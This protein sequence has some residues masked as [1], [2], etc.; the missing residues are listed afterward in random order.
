MSSFRPIFAVL[1]AIACMSNIL[2]VVAQNCGCGDGVCC[3]Q[4]GYCGNTDPYCG[5]GCREGPCSGGS[6]GGGGGGSGGGGSISDMVT[7]AFFNGI[8]DQ[9]SSSCAGKNF[10]SRSSFLDALN[11]YPEFG[12]GGSDDDTKR[13]VAAFFAHVTHETGRKYILPPFLFI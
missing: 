4:W 5:E 3:S 13:E 2:L 6:S 10:Y 11:F 8:I 7:D 9:A 1:M 12:T